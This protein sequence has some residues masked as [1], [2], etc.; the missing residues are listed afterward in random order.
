MS[1]PITHD[2]QNHCFSTTVDGHLCVLTYLL[3]DNVATFVHTGVPDAVAGRGIAAALTQFSLETAMREGWKVI[4]ACS[5]VAT[6][7]RRHPAFADLTL[8]RQ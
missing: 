1:F 6:Y 4:P 5:Y 8:K 7:L 2:L 3:D